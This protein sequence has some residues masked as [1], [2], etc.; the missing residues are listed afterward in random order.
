MDYTR[1][2]AND[3]PTAVTAVDGSVSGPSPG[4]ASP[5]SVAV[6]TPVTP[7][8]DDPRWVP[9]F[10]VER[11]TLAATGRHPEPTGLVVRHRG[12]R[13]TATGTVGCDPAP[14]GRRPGGSPVRRVGS[15]DAGD[16]VQSSGDAGEI[17]REVG[18]VVEGWGTVVAPVRT[19]GKKPDRD[20]ESW[21]VSPTD[22]IRPATLL[23]VFVPAEACIY[24]FGVEKYSGEPSAVP[25]GTGA[26][27]RATAPRRQWT[28]QP[29]TRTDAGVSP[30]RTTR[31]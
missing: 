24:S 4:E 11:T 17:A 16:G 20:E 18:D 7:H 19:A 6:R 15:N 3:S 14:A 22:D 25:A 1:R 31:A 27:T 9:G 13:T 29:G 5:Q 8:D 21:C 26:D 23:R 30:V 12:S 2:L 10:V 28:P